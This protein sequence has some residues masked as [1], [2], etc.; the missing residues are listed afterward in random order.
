MLGDRRDGGLAAARVRGPR[1]LGAARRRR[2][3][4]PGRLRELAQPVS[5]RTSGARPPAR[6]RRR[7][8][9]RVCDLFDRPLVISFWFTRGGD[10]LPTQDVVRRGRRAYRAGSTSSRSTS[11]TTARGRARSSRERGW[12]G[13]GRP[14]TATAPSPTSTGS[15]AARRSPSPTR[16]GSS[17]EAEDRRADDA[18]PSSSGSID[19]PLRGAASRERGAERGERPATAERRAPE[20][21]LGRARAARGVPRPRALRYVVVERGLGPEP[22]AR[23]RSGCGSSPTASP[24]AQAINLRQQPIPW[25]YRVFFRHIGL[26]PDEHADAGRAAR[27][28]ADAARAASSAR[29]CS[30]TR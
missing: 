23:S 27:A 16:A 10:C 22:E 25:A 18:R 13:A 5:A 11:A 17:R 14:R 24:A 8:A 4:R 30:T 21:R 26:D 15:A 2:Q 6:S 9:I 29:T 12:D 3:R 7:D 28:R 19:E 1:R 20:A